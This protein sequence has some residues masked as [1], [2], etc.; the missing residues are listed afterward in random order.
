MGGKALA[1][2]LKDILGLCG[3]LFSVKVVSIPLRLSYQWSVEHLPDSGGV[4]DEEV[5]VVDVVAAV[6]A[7]DEVVVVDEVAAVAAVAA[8]AD[9]VVV[10]SSSRFTLSSS[11]AESWDRR[12]GVFFTVVSAGFSCSSGAPFA[13]TAG[14]GASSSFS[15]MV[16]SSEDWRFTAGCC[17]L[18]RE[19]TEPV[20]RASSNVASC[21]IGEDL[22]A[23]GDMFDERSAFER[24]C[25]EDLSESREVGLDCAS[26]A[27][28]AA[29]VG[30]LCACCPG[31]LLSSQSDDSW[32]TVF[33][34]SSLADM[35]VVLWP[36]VCC[37]CSL[38]RLRQHTQSCLCAQEHQNMNCR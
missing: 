18:V 29:A 23:S 4:V 19:R 10:S 21:R 1:M 25:T 31:A 26:A 3:G 38:S 16:G 14:L 22:S 35:F 20:S 6:A 27:V 8:V 34:V 36:Q 28:A 11:P 9:V 30:E 13:A 37:S 15:W 32:G 5:T 7:V 12:R 24:V 2:L 33:G 17:R